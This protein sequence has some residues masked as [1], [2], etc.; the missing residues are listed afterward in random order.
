MKEKKK[1]EFFMSI[2]GQLAT[3]SV[4]AKKEAYETISQCDTAINDI[5]HFIEFGK[6]NAVQG[7]QILK[8]LKSA[9]QVRR[10]AKAHIDM[11]NSLAD[12]FTNLTKH[13]YKLHDKSK[14]AKRY[15]I[16]TNVLKNLS[17]TQYD[18]IECEKNE[19][20]NP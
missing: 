18:Y 20:K 10:E 9:M 7:W 17:L 15:K 12:N 19:Q 14:K 3:E 8:A 1:T 5:Y 6:Y 16:K 2:L 13:I 4:K 11:L